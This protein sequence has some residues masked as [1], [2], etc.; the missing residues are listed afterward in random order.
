M[1]ND[2]H[3]GKGVKKMLTHKH[4]YWLCLCWGRFK[5]QNEYSYKAGKKGTVRAHVFFLARYFLH[6]FK[7]SDCWEDTFRRTVSCPSVQ[8]TYHTSNTRLLLWNMV[9]I[10]SRLASNKS[11]LPGLWSLPSLWEG[12]KSQHAPQTDPNNPHPSVSQCMQI[13]AAPK[14][15]CW[16]LL[17]TSPPSMARGMNKHQKVL[18]VNKG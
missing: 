10:S 11:A 5:L 7:R 18:W 1:L 14:K 15:T 17:S 9:P 16:A 12:D 4:K 2:V 6:L 8:I 13:P 3:S